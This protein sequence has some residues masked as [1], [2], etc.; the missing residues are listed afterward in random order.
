M[1]NRW[2]Y[3]QYVCFRTIAST[4]L[5]IYFSRLLFQMEWGFSALIALLC[6]GGSVAIWSGRDD[7]AWANW[8][9][10]CSCLL[11]FLLKPELR[12]LDSY[13]IIY[14]LSFI[15]LLPPFNYTWKMPPSLYLLTWIVLGCSYWYIGYWNENKWAT[16]A[17]WSMS[18]LQMAFLPLSLWS[19]CR[20]WLWLLLLCWQCVDVH[21][22]YVLVHLAAFDPGW[23]APRRSA[24]SLYVFYDS[25]CGL[26]HRL[27]LFTLSENMYSDQFLFFPLHGKTCRHIMNK[28]NGG[29]T[30]ESVIVYDTQA[31]CLL[32]K[33]EAVIRILENLGGLWR[34]VSIVLNVF[35]LSVTNWMYDLFTPLRSLFLKKKEGKCPLIPHEWQKYII[36]D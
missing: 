13:S 12:S 3:G 30:P 16:T 11:F 23:I 27:V 35:P 24:D 18:I 5:A 7:R 15:A 29:E 36:L 2:T 19:R 25:S 33:I 34:G 17:L 9:L 10:A 22:G 31:G 26:C 1:Q 4:Y 6:L 14:L 21:F 20:P 8:A 28:K 32:F